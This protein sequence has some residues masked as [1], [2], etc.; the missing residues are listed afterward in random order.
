MGDAKHK[1][2]GGNVATHFNE[3]DEMNVK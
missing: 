2:T 1:D 3:G